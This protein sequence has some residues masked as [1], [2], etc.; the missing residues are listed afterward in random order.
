MIA[1]F[2]VI[3]GGEGVVMV[4]TPF[5]FPK[6]SVTAKGNPVNYGVDEGV[7]KG[8]C[9]KFSDVVEHTVGD[10]LIMFRYCFVLLNVNG[11][12]FNI[13]QVG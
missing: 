6:P 7:L 5:Q 13:L 8:A 10:H 3:N 12:Y 11:H 4:G 9:G 1:P 2:G